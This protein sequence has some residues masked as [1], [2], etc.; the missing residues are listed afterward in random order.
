[1]TGLLNVE[2]AGNR[3][4]DAMLPFLVGFNCL[5]HIV[6]HFGIEGSFN[7]DHVII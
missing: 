5:M 3:E 7:S 4:Q 6:D 1:V 2:R